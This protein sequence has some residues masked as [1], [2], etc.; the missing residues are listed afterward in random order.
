MKVTDV[1]DEI[2]DVTYV[3]IP[4]YYD[5]RDAVVTVTG[6][7][8]DGTPLNN[9]IYKTACDA[10]TSRKIWFS[11]GI[12]TQGVRKYNEP[13]VVWSEVQPKIDAGYIEVA[14]HGREHLGDASYAYKYTGTHTGSN[15]QLYTLTDSVASFPVDSPP[16]TRNLVG[17]VIDNTTDGSS[18]TITSSTANT[19]TCSAGLSGGTDNDWDNGDV[20]AIDRYDEE[21]GGSKQEIIDNLDLPFKKGSQEYVYAW[22]EPF[23]Y[24]DSTTRAKLRQYKYL[25]DRATSSGDAFA[26]W[27]SVNNLFNRVGTSYIYDTGL[28]KFIW[29]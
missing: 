14:S 12:T 19:V 17:W 9:E 15:N 2:V 29:R 3:G 21:I 26:T 5:N 16:Y 7:G 4:D 6:D 25:S 10:F 20:Y 27:D 11:P 18:G 1:S 24:S 23:G 28:R 22:L 13:P 8:W